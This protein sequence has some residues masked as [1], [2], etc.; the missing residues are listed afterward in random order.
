M[1]SSQ[2]NSVVQEQQAYVQFTNNSVVQEQHAIVQFTKTSLKLFQ[3]LCQ[4]HFHVVFQWFLS[5]LHLHIAQ[6]TPA[7][8]R[9]I[10]CEKVSSHICSPQSGPLTLH[11]DQLLTEKT[12]KLV[13][14]KLP[15]P[16]AQHCCYTQF[17]ASCTCF[18][19]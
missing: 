10:T 2:I 6:H 18:K 1:Y 16:T 5:V 4:G 17:P 11:R 12:E 14:V 9:S 13:H 19:H 15:F 7:Q 8:S 3:V